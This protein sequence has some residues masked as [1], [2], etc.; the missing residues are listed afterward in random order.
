MQILDKT[1]REI[2]TFCAADAEWLTRVNT[3][4]SLMPARELSKIEPQ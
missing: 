1:G 2:V 3:Y 4:N